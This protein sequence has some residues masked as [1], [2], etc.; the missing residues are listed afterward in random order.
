MAYSYIFGYIPVLWLNLMSKSH[1]IR[2]LQPN[3][4]VCVCVCVF[5]V[6]LTILGMFCTMTERAMSPP[7]SRTSQRA[8]GDRPRRYCAERERSYSAARCNGVRPL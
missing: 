2:K 6:S 8:G 1:L 4:C 7:K 3:H 5:V